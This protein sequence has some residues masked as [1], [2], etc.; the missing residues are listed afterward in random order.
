MAVIQDLDAQTQ[1]LFADRPFAHVSSGDL[2][3]KQTPRP[4][5]LTTQTTLP[6]DQVSP[7][8]DIRPAS[9]PA[10]V[11]LLLVGEAIFLIAVGAVAQCR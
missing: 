10:S 5:D 4:S 7:W 11:A 1:G 3:L 2:K 6:V 9:I 8:V